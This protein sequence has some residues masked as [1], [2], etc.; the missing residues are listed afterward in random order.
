M[1]TIKLKLD[2]NNNIIV[3]KKYNVNK[4]LFKEDIVEI[5]SKKLKKPISEISKK[6]DIID[7]IFENKFELFLNKKIINHIKTSI[8]SIIKTG[9]INYLTD[10]LGVHS[11]IERSYNPNKNTFNIK[12]S[13]KKQLED[14]IYLFEFRKGSNKSKKLFLTEYNSFKYPIQ[15]LQKIEKR[16]IAYLADKVVI[17]NQKY[18]LTE[19]GI[20]EIEFIEDSL[21]KLGKIKIEVYN[22]KNKQLETFYANYKIV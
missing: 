20:N 1:K 3:D 19:N 17:K 18:W 5:L 15:Y 22:Q 14:S 4:F 12:L 21:Q 6:T 2:K 10:T 11:N 8:N 9:E 13:Y 16:Y 7:S